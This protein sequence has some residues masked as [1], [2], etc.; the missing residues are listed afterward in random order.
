MVIEELHFELH[1]ATAHW[2]WE[3]LLRWRTS[4]GTIDLPIDLP[5]VG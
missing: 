1:A 2:P 4:I 5:I 3:A